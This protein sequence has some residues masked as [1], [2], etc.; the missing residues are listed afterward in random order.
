MGLDVAGC[1]NTK[2]LVAG[3]LAMMGGRDGE[4][5]V[6]A[7][8]ALGIDGLGLVEEDLVPSADPAAAPFGRAVHTDSWAAVA[9]EDFAFQLNGYYPSCFQ[10]PKA[11]VLDREEDFVHVHPT[12]GLADHLSYQQADKLEGGH[13]AAVE[14]PL[15][16]VARLLVDP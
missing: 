16:L 14:H 11:V 9:S 15:G 13:P 1:V 12:E 10:E 8:V 7:V 3:L 5:G 2:D 4:S 6:V